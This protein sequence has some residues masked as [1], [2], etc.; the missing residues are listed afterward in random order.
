MIAKTIDT[1][2]TVICCPWCDLP[3]EYSTFHLWDRARQQGSA[4]G[5]WYCDSCGKGFTGKALAG[6]GAEIE[7]WT[8][9]YTKDIWVLLKHSPSEAC[10]SPIYLILDTS[11]VVTSGETFEQAAEHLEFLYNEHTC[12]SNWMK[13]EVA[14]I[15]YERD[16]D[17][18]GVFEFVAARPQTAEN[19]DLH[20]VF[21]VFA[22]ILAREEFFDEESE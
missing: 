5:P 19:K 12:P 22:D 2:K 16:S 20:D 14:G 11:L 1:I 8:Q 21:D 18:H 7:L 4:F 9:S 17:P 10:C 3:T 6:G 15:R 13:G